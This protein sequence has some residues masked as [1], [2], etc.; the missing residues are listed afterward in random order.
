[1]DDE[2]GLVF[3]PE[4]GVNTP[5]GK[6]PRG[7]VLGDNGEKYDRKTGSFPSLPPPLLLVLPGKK[8]GN[9]MTTT[10]LTDLLDFTDSWLLGSVQG[11]TDI[12]RFWR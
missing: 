10:T 2:F 8:M 11:V 6:R 5:L 1:M 7:C 9:G 12:Q 4:S 3:G